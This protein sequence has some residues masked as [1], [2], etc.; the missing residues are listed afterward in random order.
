MNDET[1]GL[2][3]LAKSMMSCVWAISV[4]GMSEMGSL[5]A[6]PGHAQARKLAGAVDKLTEAATATFDDSAQAIYRTGASIQNAVI[7]AVFAMF[8]APKVSRQPSSGAEPVQAAAVLSSHPSEGHA[9]TDE[10][11]R[12]KVQ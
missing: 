3:D 11:W 2:R 8:G 9:K 7:D 12:L 10:S 6:E 1:F 4:L 5:L